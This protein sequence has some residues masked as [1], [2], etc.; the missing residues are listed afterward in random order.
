MQILLY[1]GKSF[2]SKAIQMQTRSIYSHCAVRLRDG[3]MAESWA[4]AGVRHM[5]SAFDGHTPR[6]K[7]DVYHIDGEY[8][9][10]KVEEFLLKQV[11]KDYDYASIAR[12]ISRRTSPADSKWFC[13]ELCVAAFR[14]GG[15]SLL[16]G[17]PSEHSPRDVSLSPLLRKIATRTT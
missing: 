2:I 17:N 11:G 16:N 14:Y 9:A 12:F 1:R 7:I 8:S 5:K 3:T 6:T 15:L 4:T 10:D 13:S